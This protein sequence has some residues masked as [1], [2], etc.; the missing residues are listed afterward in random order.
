[1]NYETSLN[2]AYYL[3]QRFYCHPNGRELSCILGFAKAKNNL[4]ALIQ[5][6]KAADSEDGIKDLNW[7]ENRFQKQT[8]FDHF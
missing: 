7:W 2:L 5:W 1:M 3:C 4:A 8:E 6:I